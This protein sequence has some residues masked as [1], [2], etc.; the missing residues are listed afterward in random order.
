MKNFLNQMKTLLV[1]GASGLTGFKICSIAKKQFNV[2]GT[3]NT[4]PVK[5]ENC[6]IAKIDVTQK[7]DVEQ[8]F[9]NFKPDFVI[10]TSAFHNV[11]Q[12]EDDEKLAYSSN[13]MAVKNLLDSCEKYNS[14][15]L[16]ISTDYV[17][18]G[19]KQT[20]YLESDEADPVSIYGKSKL[21]GEKLLENSKHVVI[22]PSVVY[23]WTQLELADNVSSSGK[24]MNFAMWLLTKL[25]K[26]EP[27]KI[28][29]DQFSTATLAD[30]LG[31]SA[32]KIIQS[33]TGGLFHVSGL[34]CESR[35]DFSI[36]FAKKFGYDIDLISKT[37]SSQ[38]KQKAKRPLFSCLDC[39]KTI[40]TFNLNLLSSDESL[41][42]MKTQVQKEKPELI[43]NN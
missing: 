43:G 19:L 20:P 38:F 32:I 4:R 18:S 37:D 28:V 27:V 30:S 2:I 26:K 41:N 29:T 42:I 31:E 17:F 3:Y 15:L 25:H 14:K 35:Y 24:P 16:H 33:N 7:N 13:Y 6:T 36:N 11:D 34:S 12:C 23:G 21:M 10:N 39:K 5:I 9:S 22:R 40:D 1:I 8:L